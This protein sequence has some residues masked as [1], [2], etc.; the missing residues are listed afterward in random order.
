MSIYENFI[1]KYQKFTPIQEKAIPIIAGGSNCLVIAP[2]GSGKT[3]AAVLP[4]IDRASKI[5]GEGIKILYIT[6]LRALNRDMLGR[7]R[8]MAD[9][10][11][12]TIGV[13]HGDTSNSERSKQVRSAPDI[14]VTT[15]ESLQ[16]MLPTKG[17]GV[18]LAN[19]KFVIIDE[20]HE[21]YFNKRG[22]Q[23]SLGL[24]RL[25]EKAP[26]FQ[27]VGLSA[28]V[29]N[30][31]LVKGYLAGL[32]EC[33][34]AQISEGKNFSISI[35]MPE[36]PK[37]NMSQIIDKFGLDEPSAAR[38]ECIADE[39]EE[40]S[41]TLIFA[42]TR[43]I[44]EALGSK[45][46][47]LDKI[48]PF[49][50]IG[51]HHGS[52]EK[53]ERIEIENSFRDNK[54]KSIIA[55]SSLELGIDIGSINK[56]IQYGSPRQSLR[57][58]QRIGRSGHSIS[59]TSDGTII[60][61]G[62]VDTLES[63]AVIDNLKAKEL[64]SFEVQK[65][66]LDVLANQVCGIILD[67]NSCSIDEIYTIVRRSY[68]YLTME[69]PA[70]E[71]NL[72]FMDSL[73]LIGFDG[74]TAVATSRTR[75]YYY[76]H[77]SVIPD[78]HRYRVRNIANNKII[79]TLDEEFVSNN[80]DENSI[81]ITK[82]LPWRVISIDK[83]TIVVEP[84]SN[85]DAAIPDWSGEDIPVSYSVA[86]RMRDI[87]G[88]NELGNYI[89]KS[90]YGKAE[91]F[92]EDQA[93]HWKPSSDKV[94]V[95]MYD[96]YTILYT[97]L[98]TLANDALSRL[99]AKYLTMNAGHSINIKSSPYL[100]FF[101][102]SDEIAIKSMLLGIDPVSVYQKLKE[103][104][105]ETDFFRYKFTRV[106]KIFGIIDRDAVMSKSLTKHIISTLIGSP[107]YEET[108]REIIENYFDI[109]NLIGFFKRVHSRNAEVVFKNIKK[110]SPLT[111]AILKSAYYNKELI[112]PL[113]PND[114]LVNSFSKYTLDKKAN[115]ICTYC[116][117]EFKRNLSEIID[118]GRI[119]CPTCQSP[120]VTINT[121]GYINVIKK[122]K[123]KKEL[124]ET[125]KRVRMSMMAD[126][127]LVYSYGGRAVAALSTYGVGHRTAARA[128]LM[129]RT[130][131]E[132]FFVDLIEAQKQFIKNKKYWSV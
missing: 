77:L 100:I 117:F 18:K 58:A 75:M 36:K 52:L 9:L 25:E 20:I 64:E 81:F 119:L 129:Q 114:E 72:R 106:A 94:M 60:S 40:S 89:D 121:N 95:E 59:K 92:I 11:G 51:V 73:K 102:V 83:D 14:I 39:I 110:Q 97:W 120:M 21:F 49:G 31:D 131:K 107:V 91:K 29:K 68:N 22:A 127:D 16:S 24:E 101:D 82:G 57:L 45:L 23:L 15:P 26:N 86:S 38:L 126:A 122:I 87:I 61:T 130:S 17:M 33:K 88:R 93:E 3:E 118:E 19:V 43:Q 34:I 116:G 99:I 55:T 42:N 112:M 12:L 48:H 109:K 90:L 80:I 115:L 46:L 54:I 132:K 63:V 67:K 53:D 79:S 7:L 6:P 50:G 66:A 113:M 10:A 47:Y 2:T 76:D 69:K 96:N 104:I 123:E 13:R 30:P 44:V 70:L 78:S 108:L 28:T 56:V 4:I 27:R 5:N 111:K 71:N 105:T 32:R 41:S 85:L 84:S 8:W 1:S 124:T 98:G 103:S 35:K 74:K 62:I 37:G 65:N 128:L 125:D